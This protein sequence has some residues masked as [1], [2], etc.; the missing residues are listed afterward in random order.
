MT[1]KMSRIDIYNDIRPLMP[2]YTVKYYREGFYKLVRFHRPLYPMP[3]TE[4]EEEAAESESS[5]K[6]SQAYSRA[7][8]VVQQIGLC[9][10]WPYFITLT[11]DGVRHDRYDLNAYYKVFAQWIRDYRKEFYDRYDM[12]RNF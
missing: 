6:L 8:S 10:D 9:N 2:D 7:K 3:A 1:K 5:G 12:T 4:R 11:I